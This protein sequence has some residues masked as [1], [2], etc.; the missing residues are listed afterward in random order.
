MGMYVQQGLNKKEDYQTKSKERNNDEI[1]TIID[2]TGNIRQLGNGSKCH[3]F[4]NPGFVV[5]ALGKNM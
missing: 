5:I 1:R 3:R 2:R 4:E